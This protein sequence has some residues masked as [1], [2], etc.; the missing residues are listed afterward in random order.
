MGKACRRRPGQVVLTALQLWLL[1]C[2]PTS[3]PW[4]V[5]PGS[6]L[7]DR[8]LWGLELDSQSCPKQEADTWALTHDFTQAYSTLR[9]IKCHDGGFSS[10]ESGDGGNAGATSAVTFPGEA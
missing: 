5:R 4:G 10:A 7:W 1:L 8:E 2:E 6:L 9:R 3:S